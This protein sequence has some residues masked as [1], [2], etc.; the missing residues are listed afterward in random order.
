M[1]IDAAWANG[2]RR[3]FLPAQ[4]F[5]IK[6]SV[7]VSGVSLEGTGP[8]SGCGLMQMDPDKGC[9]TIK[10]ERNGVH[11]PGGRVAGMSL[12]AAPGVACGYAV[13]LGTGAQNLPDRVSLEGLRI[14]TGPLQSGPH[15]TWYCA[16]NGNG[17]GRTSPPGFRGMTIRDVEFFNVRSP[18][19]VLWGVNAAR[20]SGVMGYTGQGVT[21]YTG[22]WIGGSSG[23]R[24]T[25]V[26]ISDCYCE[27]PLNVTNTINSGFEG[28]WNGGIQT[29]TLS[30]QY[31]VFSTD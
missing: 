23:V 6:S 22:M 12:W 26:Q 30:Q 13:V 20:I 11:V 8:V 1:A 25:D 17:T 28:R 5:K 31:C 27:G 19:I 16:I 21:A 18:G 24:S 14:T 7:D 3:V 2:F 9:I 4:L 29:D 10:G 15:G